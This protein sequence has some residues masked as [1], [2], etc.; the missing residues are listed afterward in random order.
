MPG[1]TSPDAM[2]MPFEIAQNLLMGFEPIAKL[3]HRHHSTGVNADPIKVREVF[4]LY[5]RFSPVTGKDILEIGPGHTLEVLAQAKADGAKSCTAIDVV[6]YRS[7]DQAEYGEIR[8][9]R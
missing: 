2:W 9:R 1:S 5:L 6:D 3:A 8:F 7:P 4:E